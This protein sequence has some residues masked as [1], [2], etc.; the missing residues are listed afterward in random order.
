MSTRPP[1]AFIQPGTL[2]LA[3]LKDDIAIGED[4]CRPPSAE[5]LDHVQRAGIQA[6]GERIVQQVGGD[7]QEVRIARIFGPVALQGAEIIRV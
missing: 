1:T 6:I 4:D 7:L 3:R 2:D 5:M